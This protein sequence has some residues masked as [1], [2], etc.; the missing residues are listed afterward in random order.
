MG[1]YMYRSWTIEEAAA[2]GKKFRATCHSSR[3]YE[4]QLTIGKE[5]EVEIIPRILP[6]SPLCCFMNDRGKMSEAHLE[7]FTKITEIIEKGETL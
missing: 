1:S 7:R 6:C 3:S 2:V 4:G 5:Y